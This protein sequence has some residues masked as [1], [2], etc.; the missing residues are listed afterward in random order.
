VLRGVGRGCLMLLIAM[1]LGGCS[2][3][4]R[5]EG[6]P[7]VEERTQVP[8]QSNQARA[9]SVAKGMI[10][11]PYKWGGTTPKG[12]DCSGLVKYSYNKAGLSVPRTSRDQYSASEHI[13]LRQAQTGDLVFFR[14]DRRI[15]HVGIYLGDGRFVHAPARGKSVEVA[16]LNQPPYSGAFVTAGRIA[17][18]VAR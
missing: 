8:E 7:I 17:S 6:P 13:S 14:F 4:V 1:T 10:G 12:F 16:S 11:T 15:S 18:R 3:A 5:W 9:A 2:N